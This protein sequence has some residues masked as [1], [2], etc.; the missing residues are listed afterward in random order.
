M[1]KEWPGIFSWKRPVQEALEPAK[2]RHQLS[3]SRQ[4]K[5]VL[6]HLGRGHK[7]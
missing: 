7:H 5:V 6:K 2:D 3:Q 1:L 4:R